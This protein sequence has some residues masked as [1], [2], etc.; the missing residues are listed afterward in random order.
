MAS[1]YSTKA[2]ASSDPHGSIRSE[3]GL[4]DLKLARP[5]V[6]CGRDD[7]T[8]PEQ[9]FA[10]GWTSWQNRSPKGSNG[11]TAWKAAWKPERA[12]SSNWAPAGHSTKWPQ[13]IIPRSRLVV[14]TT[15]EPCKA[16]VRGFHVRAQDLETAN[17][18]DETTPSMRT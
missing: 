1:L 12:R 10:G 18:Y 15:S 5:C 2:A 4:L 6:L 9:L 11:R 13:A 3:D 8:N 7:A 14:W 17:T 16:R